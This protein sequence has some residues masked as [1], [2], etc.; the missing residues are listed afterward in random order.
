MSLRYG[1]DT[2]VEVNLDAVKHNVREFKKRVNDK[3]IA[4]MA[5]VKANA[6]GHGAVE[7]AK[8]AIEAGVN[9]LA[10]A[11]VDEGIELREAGISEPILILGYTPVEAAIDAIEYDIMMTVYRIE[12]LKGID[13]VAQQLEKKARVQV[14]I[15]T[16]MSRIGLQEEE[17]SPFLEELKKMKHVEVEGMFTHYSTAD[18]IDKTYTNMQTNLFEKAVNTAKEI[19]IHL[20]YIHSSNSAGSMEL[21]NTFQ[22]L[23]RVGIGIYG[24]YP[25]Q[26]VDHTVV[27]LQPV[28]SLKSKVA[29]IKHAQKNR[30]VSY[31]NTY[32]ATGEEWIATVPIGYADGYN[33]QLSNKGHAL[34]NGIRVPVLGRVCMDQLMLDVT[35]AM[36]VQVGD[37]VVF[38]GKQGEEEI[39]VEEIADM[40]GTINY[41]VTCMLD[42]RIPRVYKENDEMTAVVN[43]LRKK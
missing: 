10:V 37:E 17:V 4:M 30:G 27:S 7:V 33:R 6:Y 29:H 41:E 31:G 3:N 22:N 16:G 5:A 23:V 12:D 15:D 24:M 39:P 18:E 35:K 13:K 40:L 43:I 34:I 20:P 9:Q 21:S 1:R 14:K 8:A 28:L 25:S 2:I 38:Y 26:E 42:R 19:G 32:V 36:P 11:F